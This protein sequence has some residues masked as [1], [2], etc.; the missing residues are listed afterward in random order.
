MT[1]LTLLYTKI[2]LNDTTQKC[3]IHFGYFKGQ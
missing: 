3:G 1:Q 2:D